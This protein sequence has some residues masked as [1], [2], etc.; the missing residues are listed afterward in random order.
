MHVRVAVNQNIGL[1]S[2]QLIDYGRFKRL[3]TAPVTLAGQAMDLGYHFK[4]ESLREFELTRLSNYQLISKAHINLQNRDGL[5]TTKTV[6][7]NA[8]YDVDVQLQPTHYNLLPG[9]QLGLI[10]YATDMEMTVRGNQPLFYTVDL[11]ATNLQVPH[12]R[13]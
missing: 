9:H 11:K 5:T 6:S 3:T 7:P 8:F 1:L 2:L 12:L 10:I 4:K 13:H